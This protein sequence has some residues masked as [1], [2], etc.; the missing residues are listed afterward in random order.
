M[1]L[2]RPLLAAIVGAALLAPER[3]PAAEGGSPWWVP[4]AVQLQHAGNIGWIAAGPAWT[5]WERRVH[6]GLLVGHVPEFAGGPITGVAAR[7]SVWPF[8]LDLGSTFH[9]R[10]L[11]LGGLLHY[12]FGEEYF[13]SA[14]DRFPDGY[15]DYSTALRVALLAGASVGTSSR[16]L[17]FDRTEFYLEVGTTDLEL[18]LFLDNMDSRPLADAL[19]LAVGLIFWF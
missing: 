15:Y 11:E 2:R 10:P 13:L 14:P 8:E 12:T 1:A 9:L 7:L 6:F 3:A 18:F 19:H 16:V 5:W 17:F 4:D